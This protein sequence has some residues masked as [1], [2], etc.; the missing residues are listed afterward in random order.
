MTA[1]REFTNPVKAAIVKRAMTPGGLVV[2]EG[3]GL[4]LGKKPYHIDHTTPDALILDK[5][6]ALTADDGK[7]LGWDCCHKPKTAED[8]GNIARAKRRELKDIGIKSRSSFP[9]LPPGWKYDWKKRRPVYQ[10]ER[11]PVIRTDRRRP[12]KGRVGTV[13]IRK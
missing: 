2:C 11:V 1:R 13:E 12:A 3:C 6:K 5:R 4:V 7:L 10:G 8:I 9:K